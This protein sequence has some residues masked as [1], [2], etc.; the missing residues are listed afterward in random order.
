MNTNLNII[1]QSAEAET[2]GE[3]RH[4]AREDRTAE[5]QEDPGPLRFTFNAR[6]RGARHAVVTGKLINIVNSM[7]K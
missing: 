3:Q 1:F 4:S 6:S 2:V 7:L 5:G